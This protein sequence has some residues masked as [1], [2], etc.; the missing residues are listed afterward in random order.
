MG[1]Q[2]TGANTNNRNILDSKAVQSLKTLSHDKSSFRTWNDKFINVFTQV[3][4]KSRRVFDAMCKFI[5]KEETG[6]F[7]FQMEE[8]LFTSAGIDQDTSDE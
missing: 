7:R 3:R 6:T 4:Q 8:N 1:R 5:D 2:G